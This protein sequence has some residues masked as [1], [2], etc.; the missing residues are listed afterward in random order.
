MFKVQNACTVGITLNLV[1]NWNDLIFVRKLSKLLYNYLL[2]QFH[3]Y[4]FN[5]KIDQDF[6]CIFSNAFY[7]KRWEHNK[8]LYLKSHTQFKSLIQEYRQRKQTIFQM[9]FVSLVMSELP[10]TTGDT[11]T[12]TW[13]FLPEND[14]I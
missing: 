10:Q 6:Y 14:A 1:Y 12:C 4:D 8:N 7:I 3:V 2:D 9:Q 13:C 11:L 5:G